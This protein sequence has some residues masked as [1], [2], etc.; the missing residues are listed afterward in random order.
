[1]TE[2][3]TVKRTALP[4]KG[5]SVASALFFLIGA[6]YY[7]YMLVRSAYESMCSTTA[8]NISGGPV[9]LELKFS[10]SNI[11]ARAVLGAVI[12]VALCVLTVLLIVFALKNKRHILSAVFSAVVI[13]AQIHLKQFTLLWEFMF[14]RYAL[15]LG[16]VAL[17]IC[18][19]IKYVPFVIALIFSVAAYIRI[20]YDK[21]MIE[22]EGMTEDK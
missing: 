22:T 20:R 4:A 3:K 9:K 15:K 1:M 19:L 18:T 11:N 10:F 21:G 2:T 7:S 13:A 17:D 14:A 8:E 6:I 12:V 5:L 16:G